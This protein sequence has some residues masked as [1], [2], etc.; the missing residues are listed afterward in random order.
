M[1]HRFTADSH[2]SPT[3]VH[4]LEGRD[5]PYQQTSL[6][7]HWPARPFGVEIRASRCH[8][9]KSPTIQGQVALR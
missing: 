6:W 4:L 3:R 5:W 2:H 1:V 9:L 7:T 8:A